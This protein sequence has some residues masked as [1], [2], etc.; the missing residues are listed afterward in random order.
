MLEI[1]TSESCNAALSALPDQLYG[2]LN[3]SRVRSRLGQQTGAAIHCAVAIKHVRI[4][5]A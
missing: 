2:E 1:N 4:A 5:V 3:L